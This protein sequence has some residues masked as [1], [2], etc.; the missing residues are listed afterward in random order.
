MD[1]TLYTPTISPGSESAFS[2]LAES[3]FNLVCSS[4]VTHY[5]CG[6]NEEPPLRITDCIGVVLHALLS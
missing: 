4:M 2:P 1:D 5:F 3:C 6:E